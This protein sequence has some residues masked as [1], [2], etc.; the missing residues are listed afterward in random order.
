MDDLLLGNANVDKNQSIANW[1]IH[2]FDEDDAGSAQPKE[3]K[4]VVAEEEDDDLN[5]RVDDIVMNF[6]LTALIFFVQPYLLLL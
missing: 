1:G 5:F 4:E 2:F 6:C 3:A